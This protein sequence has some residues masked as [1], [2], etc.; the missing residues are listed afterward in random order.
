MEDKKTLELLEAFDEFEQEILFAM[1]RT[2]KISLEQAIKEFD[3]V[4]Y[5]Q[6]PYHNYSSVEETLA[7]DH[8]ESIYGDISE[9]P[10]EVLEDY[11]DYELFGSN[12]LCKFAIDKESNMAISKS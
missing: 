10:R 7:Y 2:R 9:V 4:T 3:M 11:F 12:L 5:V 8:I 1:T 6:L